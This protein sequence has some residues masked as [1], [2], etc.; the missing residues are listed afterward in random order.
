MPVLRVEYSARESYRLRT[1]L[2]LLTGT[3]TLQTTRKNFNQFDIDTTCQLCG[4][5]PETESHFVLECSS[6]DIVRGTVLPSIALQWNNLS[7]Q[8]FDDLHNAVKLQ[9][10]INCWP[11]ITKYIKPPKPEAIHMLEIECGRLLFNLDRARI[12]MLGS[13][14]QR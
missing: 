9:I 2:R 14:A 11:V 4:E 1:K 8:R 10:I 6:L 3:Y 12:L 7:S 13:A 5:E